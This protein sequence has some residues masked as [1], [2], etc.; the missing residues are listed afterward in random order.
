MLPASRLLPSSS[1]GR[2]LFSD[3]S[4]LG[5]ALDSGKVQISKLVPLVKAVLDKGNDETVWTQVYELERS[6]SIDLTQQDTTSKENSVQLNVDSTTTLGN[7]NLAIKPGS[8]R[9]RLPKSSV[10][11][12]KRWCE[13]HWQDP[14]PTNE[15]KDNLMYATGL[16]SN[17]LSSWFV[18]ARRRGKI[19]PQGALDRVAE[20]SRSAPD[21]N[22]ISI[23]NGWETMKPLDRWR[24]SPPQDEAASLS[25]ISRAV[26]QSEPTLSDNGWT[27]CPPDPSVSSFDW[28][29]SS[30]S[31]R[32]SHSSQ[33]SLSVDSL[34]GLGGQRQRR[35]RQK[36]K[37]MTTQIPRG[38]ATN[39]P[40]QCT[41]CTDSFKTK[42]DWTRHEKTLH[43]S[44]ETWTCAR[45]GPIDTSS[46]DNKVV[47]A[48]CGIEDPSTQHLESHG[49]EDCKSKPVAART[50]YRK[51]HLRQHLRL[52]HNVDQFI[53]PMQKWKLEIKHVKSRCKYLFVYPTCPIFYGPVV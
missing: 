17:Q 19:R 12:L 25:S 11:I 22:S 6:P 48:F 43:L 41:F 20:L 40:Y 27:H 44:L 31:A 47:C 14:Y 26:A 5:Q 29:Q 49:F 45:F 2:N 10:K 46:V 35:R 51:D 39:R 7:D 8:K 36:R 52:V 42:F 34:D 18:N 13:D 33:Y 50:F 16:S 21:T 24:H 30:S 32:S 28:S 4:Q 53:P 23:A 15:E 37:E 3:L 9:T 38:G 1:D